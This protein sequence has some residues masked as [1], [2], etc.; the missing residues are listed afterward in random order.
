MKIGIFH[1]W[2]VAWR[3]GEKVLA[4]I[5]KSVPTGD[6]WTHVSNIEV[7][8]RVGYE[9]DDVH[10]TCFSW[11]PVPQ[12][13]Y[14]I[15]SP[16]CYLAAVFTPSRK[17]DLILSSESGPI[18]GLRKGKKSVHVCYC[19]SPFRILWVSLDWYR[20]TLGIW[21]YL[22]GVLRW[23]LRLVDRWSARSVDLFI[24]NS[25]YIRDRIARVYGRESIVIHP[26]VDLDRFYV[27]EK[28]GDYF[29]WLGELVSYKRPDLV[30]EA[31]NKNGLPLVVAGQGELLQEL[32]SSAA[33]NVSF[34]GR[35]SDEKLPELLS[36]AQALLYAGVEDFG[37]VF[38]EALA[39]GTPVIALAEGGVKD[40]VTDGTSGILFN[41]QSF[42]GLNN[43][44]E[45][46]HEYKNSFRPEK[47]RDSAERFRSERFRN[48]FREAINR[49][50][51]RKGCH[52]V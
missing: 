22:F 21:R 23:P 51:T 40:I 14:K 27:S 16:L 37:I 13:T 32:K 1:Y 6:L 11:L 18:K 33:A 2:L 30:V 9:P 45:R 15:F 35:V 50:L 24:A 39:S 46:F 38:V 52:N 10:H 12:K 8:E 25:T 3:G 31:F 41:D 17:Y 47:L 43:A 20:G 44:I 42:D 34:T 29:L 19:H 26:P 28:K 49:E 4:E 36:R 5:V 48:E 7:C